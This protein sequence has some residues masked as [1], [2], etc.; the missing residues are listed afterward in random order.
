METLYPIHLLFPSCLALFPATKLTLPFLQTLYPKIY[1]LKPLY[2]PQ[3][4][5]ESA[6]K[7]PLVSLWLY[8][9]CLPFLSLLLA[10]AVETH[11][12]RAK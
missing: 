2:S 12:P 1:P 8:L 3:E 6:F 9:L 5:L 7:V 4:V 11:H 10:T